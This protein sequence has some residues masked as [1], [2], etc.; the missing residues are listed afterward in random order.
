MN[1]IKKLVSMLIIIGFSLQ[2][3]ACMRCCVT[4]DLIKQAEQ[5]PK[6]V[7]YV[8]RIDKVVSAYINDEKKELTICVEGKLAEK[9]TTQKFTLKTSL[10]VEQLK[11]QLQ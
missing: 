2:Q 7:R 4:T 6:T 10:N 3:T 11:K 1:V 5:P 9:T 8:D